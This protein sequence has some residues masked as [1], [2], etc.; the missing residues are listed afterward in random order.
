[1]LKSRQLNTIIINAI[2]VKMLITFPHHAIELCGNAAWISALYCMMIAAVLFYITRVVYSSRRNV[3]EIAEICGGKALRIIVGLIVFAVLSSNLFTVIR[4]FP[5]I[6]R[7]VLLQ[8]TYVEF[9]GMLFIICIVFGAN[10]GIE[11][12]GR[13]HSMFIPIAG[14]VFVIFLLL[15]IPSINVDNI[16]PVLGKGAKGIFFDNISFL[17][18]FSDLLLLNILLPQTENLDCYKKIGTKAVFIAGGCAVAILLVYGLSY[19]YPITEKYI[20]PIYQLERLIRVSS[21]F[22]RLEAILQFVWS[23]LILLYGSLYLSVLSGVWQ[24][25]FGLKESKPVIMAIAAGLVGLAVIPKSLSDMIEW[26]NIINRWIYIP[27]F[28]LPIIFGIIAKLK[29]IK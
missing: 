14:I 3:I 25:S 13:V 5:E 17:S 21:F 7:M 16:M 27:A 9:I 26:E 6:I 28:A 23:I 19:A 11:A 4:I 22:S 1:M 24:R 18:V 20:I 8:Q 29:R 12:I 10:C 2:T 15:L